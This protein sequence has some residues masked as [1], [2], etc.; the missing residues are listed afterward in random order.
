M[1][2]A[3]AVQP[4]HL[5][6]SPERVLRA[7]REANV[8][9]AVTAA[10]ILDVASF[11]ESLGG[12]PPHRLQ[13]SH[14]LLATVLGVRDEQA[15]RQERLDSIEVDAEHSLC[16]LERAPAGEDGQSSE[17]H[18]FLFVEQR[19]APIERR[20]KRLLAWRRIA[21]SAHQNGQRIV[22]ALDYLLG[23]QQRRVRRRELDGQG[24]PVETRADLGNG[25]GVGFVEHEAEVARP[26]A[27]YEELDCR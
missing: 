25:D 1:V 6:L 16:R 5:L 3:Q 19:I 12:V 7:F 20:A 11:H 8:V 10:D 21:R 15:L 9:L 23:R 13:H 17:G 4:G 2:G 14:T 27:L 18:L 24:H 26:A 22:Q